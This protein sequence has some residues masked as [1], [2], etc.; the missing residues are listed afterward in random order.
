MPDQSALD[1]RYFDSNETYNCP[2]CNR[3]HVP[4]ALT[5]YQSFDWNA[6]KTC[7]CYFVQCKACLKTSLHHSWN[8][9]FSSEGK[10]HF[11][12]EFDLDAQ[13]FHS[14]PTSF[15]VQDERMPRLLRELVTE[16]EGCLKMNFLTGASACV[17]KAIYEFTVIEKAKGKDYTKRVKFLKK[18]FPLVDS[19]HFFVTSRT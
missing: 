3:N 2:F 17:R 11:C 8:L 18:K 7:W 13:I 5:A 1:K 6:Q 9:I 15:F 10:L 19:G 14:I 12:S 16:A 4:F